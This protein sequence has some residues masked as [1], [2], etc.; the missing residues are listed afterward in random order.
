MYKKKNIK[1]ETPAEERTERR[2]EKIEDNMSTFR[3]SLRIIRKYAMSTFRVSLCLIGLKMFVGGRPVTEYWTE[4]RMLAETEHVALQNLTTKIDHLAYLG[5]VV[6]PSKYN[7]C[8]VQSTRKSSQVHNPESVHFIRIPKTA[9]TLSMSAIHW[10]GPHCIKDRMIIHEHSDGCEQITKCNGTFI[11]NNWTSIAVIREPCERFLS[12]VAHLANVWP[13]AKVNLAGS[14]WDDIVDASLNFLLESKC[15]YNHDPSC[16]VRH[17]NSQLRF[18][19]TL[20]NEPRKHGDDGWRNRVVLYPQSF[21]I[22]E[23]V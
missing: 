6:E 14:G 12:A 17:I 2:T 13:H 4:H 16:L 7:D 3:L 20:D 1:E 11:C 23:T 9:S 22:G 8:Q 21:F 19:S 18:S 15:R 10:N 5:P